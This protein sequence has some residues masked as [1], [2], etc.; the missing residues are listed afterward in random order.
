MQPWW[1]AEVPPS[2][3]DG[4]TKPLRRRLTPLWVGWLLVAA[5]FSLGLAM[6]FA[7]AQETAP[8]HPP[9]REL[10]KLGDLAS[11]VYELG[12]V[13][14]DSKGTEHAVQRYSTARLPDSPNLRTSL[15]PV[16]VPRSWEWLEDSQRAPRDSLLLPGY[17]LE[18]D[19]DPVAVGKHVHVLWIGDLA[20][21]PNLI[22]SYVERGFNIT[23]HTSVDN[24]LDGFVPHVRRAYERVIPWAAGFDFLK[25]LMLYKYGGFVVDADT[26]PLVDGDE[27][28][29]PPGCKVMLGKKTHLRS[30]KVNRP[31]Q[32]LDWAMVAT[33]P[34]NFHSEEFILSSMR[35]V[36]GL[37]SMQNDMMHEIAGS[38]ML[39]DYVSLLHEQ[40]GLDYATAYEN[41]EA[42]RSIE[43]LCMLDRELRGGWILH[44]HMN[45]WHTES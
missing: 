44:T 5:C 33:E 22:Y 11:K 42:V 1:S 3:T 19:L 43:E 21:A 24:I 34:R 30:G 45:S 26:M 8:R 40:H 10:R 18:P 2:K 39:S 38:G 28:S 4:A 31:Y 32:L 23:I 35:H 36:L 16:R 13:D 29:L 6:H 41:R 20:D 37:R 17:S 9:S 25:L 15:A 7:F 27:F 14:S 12:I